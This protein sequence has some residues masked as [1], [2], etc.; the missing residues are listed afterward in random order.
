[1]IKGE[2][3]DQETKELLKQVL[4]DE[5]VIESLLL[6]FSSKGEEDKKRNQKEQ[7]EANKNKL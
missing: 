5:K 7:E 4:K 1:M 3:G 2:Q 6:H